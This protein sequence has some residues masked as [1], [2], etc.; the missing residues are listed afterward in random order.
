MVGS[1]RDLAERVTPQLDRQRLETDM[2]ATAV[3]E[4]SAAA[5]PNCQTC[6]EAADAPTTGRH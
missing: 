4:M 3:T 1:L 2:V 5:Q 6:S